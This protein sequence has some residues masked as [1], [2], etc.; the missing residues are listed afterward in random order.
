MKKFSLIVF[1]ILSGFTYCFSQ[2][3]K[4]DTTGFSLIKNAALNNSQT[5]DNLYVFCAVN[6]SRLMWSP[7]YKKSADWIKNKLG[8]WGITNTYYEDINSSG[9]S[10]ELKKF[11]AVMT[12][13]YSYSIIGNPKE[14]TPGTNGSI[15]SEVIQL[16]V[17]TPE[18]LEKYKGKLNGKIVCLTDPLVFRP[19]NGTFITRFSDDSLKVLANYKIPNAEEKKKAE[20]DEAANNKAYVEYF[21]FLTKKVEFCKNEGAVLLID[22]GYRYY[23]LNQI[24]ANTATVPPKDI[25]DYLSV[26]AGDPNIPESMPQISIS[27]EQYNNIIRILDSGTPVTMEVNIEV[28]K[29]GIEKG[30]NVIAEIPGTELKDEVVVIG[31]HLDSYSYATGATDNAA[32][33]MNCLEVMRIIKSLGIQ[34]KRTIRVALWGAEEEGLVGSR[35]HIQKH[36]IKGN[37]K[38]YTYFNMDFGAG[39]YRGIYTEENTGAADIFGEWMKIIDD[40]KFK[41]TSLMKVKNSDQESFS[42]AGLS[43]FAFI[44]DPMDYYRIYHT[45][46]DFVERVYK[47]DITT[48]SFLMCTFAWLSA[49]AEGD[50]PTRKN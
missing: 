38:L 3:I 7:Q 13:P 6:G 30:F 40:N 21:S 37:E 2:G 43:G 29:Y 16:K 31:A 12:E 50:F 49:N 33:V 19:N 26:Y 24:W 47:D 39:R 46:M 20:E 18:D 8:E 34:P 5:L 32:S 22:P 14:W 10:W 48:N 1:L 17:K 28:E 44:Q 11:Y 9:K 27:L 36:F 42:E 35:Y 41:T 15:K 25:F 4:T 45:N 23:G